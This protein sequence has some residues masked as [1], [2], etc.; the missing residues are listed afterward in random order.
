MCKGHTLFL[1]C[2][3]L[4]PFRIHP[5]KSSTVNLPARFN[6]WVRRQDFLGDWSWL[7]PCS[8]HLH[9]PQVIDS[10]AAIHWTRTICWQ[11]LTW[12]RS[13]QERKEQ[14]LLEQFLSGYK[15]LFVCKTEIGRNNDKKRQGDV[16]I[17][18]S[19]KA[20]KLTGKWRAVAKQGE[21]RWM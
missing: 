20:G 4:L 9:R 1:N 11:T 10:W 17:H 18:C 14:R 5:V 21:V 7:C 19:D 13:R 12:P 16:F 8:V 15:Y 6:K 2:L 3:H